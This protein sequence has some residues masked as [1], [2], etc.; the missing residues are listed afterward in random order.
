ML[1]TLALL[2]MA[3][4]VVGAQ[5]RDD[6]QIARI[7]VATTRMNAMVRF[8]NDVFHARMKEVDIGG[9]TMQTGY[10][11]GLEL[12]L[13]PNQVSRVRAD[14]N[15]HMLRVRVGDFDALLKRVRGSGGTV[16]A[17]PIMTSGE[18][19]VSVRDPDGNTI[20]L[21][22]SSISERPRAPVGF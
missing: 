18:R 5:S 19:I 6:Y 17:A 3:P 7:T 9:I 12:L 16:D 1:L 15:R 4:L 13:C 10:V 11:A 2:A 22:T 20:E 8:Y 14:L 21:V